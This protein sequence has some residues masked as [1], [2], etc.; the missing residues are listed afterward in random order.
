M[1]DVKKQA[2]KSAEKL[3]ELAFDEVVA[4]AE[5]YVASSE[6]TLDNSL[7]EGLKLLK[8]SFLDDLVDKIDGEEG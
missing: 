8:S 6:S 4:I 1:S 3:V 2:I 5:V 7:L